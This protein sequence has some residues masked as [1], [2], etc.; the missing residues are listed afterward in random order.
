MVNH[1][2]LE[3]TGLEF[4]ISRRQSSQKSLAIAALT[5]SGILLESPSS[6]QLPNY[7]VV[8]LYRYFR[9]VSSYRLQNRLG[10]AV[11]AIDASKQAN[12]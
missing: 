6:N 11:S 8:P 2:D 1:Q 4:Q 9:C 3:R 5:A 7:R 12:K 10:T